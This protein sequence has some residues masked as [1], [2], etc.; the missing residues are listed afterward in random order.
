MKHWK[1]FTIGLVIIV[2]ATVGWLVSRPDKPVPKTAS[3]PVAAVNNPYA[4]ATV[5]RL[6][7]RSHKLVSPAGK[8]RLKTGQHVLI[9]IDSDSPKDENF[10]VNGQDGLSAEVEPNQ[11]DDSRA[12][13]I[14]KQ[15]GSF[16]FGLSPSDQP[17]VKYSLGDL[18]VEP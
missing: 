3:K 1:F 14:P 16:D 2:L 9:K 7:V 5:V 11:P 6:V 4:G 8:L 18:E 17:D 10:Y 15:A 12:F 13:F